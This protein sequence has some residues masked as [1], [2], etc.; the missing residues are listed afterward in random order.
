MAVAKNLCSNCHFD[1]G[2][3]IQKNYTWKLYRSVLEK[4]E[5]QGIETPRKGKQT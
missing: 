5:D 1:G 2:V 3:Q 4:S